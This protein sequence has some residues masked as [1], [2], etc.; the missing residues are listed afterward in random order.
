MLL[1]VC[2]HAG[3]CVKKVRRLFVIRDLTTTAALFC[4][5]CRTTVLLDILIYQQACLALNNRNVVSHPLFLHILI[6][7][8]QQACLALNNNLLYVV[9][10]ITPNYFCTSSFVSTRRPG[11]L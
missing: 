8:Y 10:H 6:P 9:S 1:T 4:R 11:L 3:A 7:E 5:V 2:V